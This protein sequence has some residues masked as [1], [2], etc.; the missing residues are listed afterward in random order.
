MTFDG[1]PKL[2]EG[3]DGADLLI[4]DGQPAMDAGL[5]NAVYL[6]LFS[7]PGWWGNAVSQEYEKLGSLLESIQ[8][9]TLTNTTRQDAEEY[10]KQALSWMVTDGVAKKVTTVATIPA[11]GILGLTITIEQPD[12]T[13]T[14]RYSITWAEFAVR[15]GAS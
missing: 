11:V 14:V 1:D 4:I 2:Y 15:M 3:G 9:R 12:Q 6:S 8:S 10:A 13:S 7:A 5:E